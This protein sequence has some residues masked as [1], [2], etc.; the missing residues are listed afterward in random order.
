MFAQTAEKVQQ[1]LVSGAPTLEDRRLDV[2]SAGHRRQ[3]RR[4][5]FRL[6][7][8][9][10]VEVDVLPAQRRDLPDAL[11][12]RFEEELRQVSEESE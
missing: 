6:E 12:R 1:G 7:P 3:I 9:A 4:L 5:P 2:H 11:R 10:A 8:I